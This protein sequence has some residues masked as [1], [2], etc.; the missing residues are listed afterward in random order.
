MGNKCNPVGLR[1]G[2]GLG[3][4]WSNTW[5]AYKDYSQKVYEDYIVYNFLK[6]ELSRAG[7]SNIEILR[8]SDFTEAV[9]T[10]ARPGIILGKAGLDLK[11]V[12]LTLSERIQKKINIKVVEEKNPDLSA[13]LLALW[14][15]GQLE[16]RIPFRRAMKMAMQ[17]AMKAGAEGIRVCSSGRLAGAE[18]A[19]IEWYKE[20]KVP[21]HTLRA[22]I[23]YAFTEALTTFGKIGVK[24]WV[25][26]GQVNKKKLANALAEK[27]I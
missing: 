14:I 4:E 5:F 9:V 24:V 23:D 6:E 27:T 7:V 8:K 17:R 15:T 22:D 12:Q 18:I 26:K 13:R 10:V 19:R 3:K 1:V 16:K 2:I 21:L 11:Q 25:Y 20:G